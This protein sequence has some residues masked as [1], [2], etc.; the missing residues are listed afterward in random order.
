MATINISLPEAMQRFVEEQVE[1][2]GY[3]TASDYIR[4]LI[5][6]AQKRA[7]EEK[8]LEALLLEGL[9]SGEPLEVT[10]EYWERKR[11]DL[12]ERQRRRERRA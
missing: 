6:Q 2:R 3:D 1:S 9:D 8:R 10:P 5:H 4:E 11:A 7:E 12:L